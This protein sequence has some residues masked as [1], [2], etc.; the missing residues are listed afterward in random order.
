MTD[1]FKRPFRKRHSSMHYQPTNRVNRFLSQAINARSV[2]CDKS[3]HVDRITLRFRESDKEREYRKD[4]DLGFTTAM[5]CSLLLLILG[6][7]L[8]VSALPRTLILLLLFLTAFVWISAIL[9]LLLAV[10]LKWIV[11]DLARSFTLRLAITI[12]TIVLIYSVGQVNVVSVDSKPYP[13]FVLIILYVFIYLFTCIS[14]LI[15]VYSSLALWII[16]VPVTSQYRHHPL[17]RTCSCWHIIVRHTE[18]ARCHSMFRFRRLL[19]FCQFQYFYG[20]SGG[21]NYSFLISFINTLITKKFIILK[22]H[23]CTF[24]LFSFAVCQ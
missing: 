17:K 9:M 16:P 6:A 5:G 19:H 1:K 8:Q 4:F 18:N 12:F 3:E 13:I 7:G 23:M 10:R 21:L 14:L 20:E 11:W 24:I 2:D 15:N 22:L